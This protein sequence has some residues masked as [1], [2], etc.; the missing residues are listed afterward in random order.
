[1]GA[2]LE[3]LLSDDSVDGVVSISEPTFNPVAVGVRRQP[4]G[5]LRRYAPD[6]AGMTRRQEAPPFLRLNGNFYAWR[7]DFIRRLQ[8]SW[9]DEGVHRGF[10]IPERE[11]FS[12]DDEYE[13]ELIEALVRADFVRLP[14]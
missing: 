1:M 3:Q 12:V 13:F 8:H 5:T 4:D 11:A 9:L 6:A 7:S 14:G 10:E 2:A